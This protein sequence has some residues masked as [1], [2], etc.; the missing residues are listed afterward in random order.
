M[1]KRWIMTV[2]AGLLAVAVGLAHAESWPTRP[3]TMVVPFAA[4]APTDVVGRGMGERERR[5]PP[6]GARLEPDG[7]RHIV[8]NG[9]VLHDSAG[10]EACQHLVSVSYRTGRC[11]DF[12]VNGTRQPG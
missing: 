12:P 4:G 6:G 1:Q 7:E 11:P 5:L 10:L 3:I 8:V 2:A 9:N